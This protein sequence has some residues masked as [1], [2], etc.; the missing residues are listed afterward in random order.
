MPHT[1]RLRP[2][3]ELDLGRGDHGLCA[4]LDSELLQYRG[5]VRLDGCFGDTELV[6]NLFVEQAL[7]QHH[8]YAHLLWRQRGKT[9]QQIG[10]FGI[11]AGAEIDVGWCP[12]A[13][14][15]HASNR[16]SHILDSESL[17]NKARSSEVHATEDYS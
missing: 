12:N 6:S 14:L 3:A 4:T 17:R 8:Q 15:K 13:A 11:R 1:D 16:P 9:R 10:G 2:L 7:R 5:D